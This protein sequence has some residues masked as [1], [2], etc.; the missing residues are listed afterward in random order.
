MLLFAQRC[1]KQFRFRGAYGCSC[2]CSLH[3]PK[4]V[5][6]LH[7]ALVQQVCRLLRCVAF[8]NFCELTTSVALT[9]FD[10]VMQGTSATSART[11]CKRLHLVL[12]VSLHCCLCSAFEWTPPL[13]NLTVE[14]AFFSIFSRFPK[15]RAFTPSV[16]SVSFS[17]FSPVFL[18]ADWLLSEPYQF[19]HN[20]L[21]YSSSDTTVSPF[22]INPDSFEVRFVCL[23]CVCVVFWVCGCVLS[24]FS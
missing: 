20:V 3:C 14:C 19:E 15:F 4:V 6:M 17:S 18:C 1:E 24:C 10:K 7:Q 9:L 5:L 12:L 23:L 16:V 2:C 13:V 22:Y 21:G 11:C 8:S